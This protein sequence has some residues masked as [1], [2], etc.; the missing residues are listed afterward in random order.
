MLDRMK[1]GKEESKK[2]EGSRDEIRKGRKKT[3]KI[4]KTGK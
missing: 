3:S 4:T 2:G 1:M